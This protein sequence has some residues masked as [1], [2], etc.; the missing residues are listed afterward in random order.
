MSRVASR[1]IT[2]RPSWVGAP[3]Q[4][5]TRSRATA[6]AELIAASAASTS[7]ARRVTNRD[8]VGSEAT[9]PNT[10]GW[11]RTRATSQAASPPKATATARSSTTFPESW[12]AKGSRHGPNRDDSSRA[13]PLR[14]AVST[15][16]VPPACDTSDSLPAITDNH[17]LRCLSFTCEV[18]LIRSDPSFS[19]SDPTG[20]SRHFRA[21]NPACRPQ[22]QLW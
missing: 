1:S 11:A 16:R 8:T 21:S 15:S 6:R 14:R 20:L 5:H 19:N 17:G 13:N 4:P 9:N 12:T 7:S 22:D 10:P 18:P 2:T 3:A